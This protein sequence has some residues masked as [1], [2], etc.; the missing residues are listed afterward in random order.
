MDGNGSVGLV[1]PGEELT[2]DVKSLTTD[3]VVYC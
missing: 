3:T 2:V 1:D